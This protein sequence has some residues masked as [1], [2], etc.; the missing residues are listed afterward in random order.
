MFISYGGS[1]TDVEDMKDPD[2]GINVT[3]DVRDN[4]RV[5]KNERGMECGSGDE[6]REVAD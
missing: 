6:E 1:I 5:V 3:G 2:A 4:S